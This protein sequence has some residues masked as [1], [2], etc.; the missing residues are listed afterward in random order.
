MI[1]LLLVSVIKKIQPNRY[2]F[3]FIFILSTLGIYGQESELKFP[4]ATKEK[5]DEYKRE[6]Q[7]SITSEINAYSKKKDEVVV[8]KSLE[9]MQVL[10]YLEDDGYDFLKLA[11]KDYSNKSENFYNG[12]LETA[13]ALYQTGFE[14]E[15]EKI[16]A[17]ST[18]VR[19]FTV[20]ANFLLR[21]YPEEKSTYLSTL[22]SRFKNYEKNPTLKILTKYLEIPPVEYLAKRP[23]IK[24]L[25][26]YDF[27]GNHFVLFSLQRL[28]R[29]YPGLVIIKN[30]DGKFLRRED[31]TIF[32]I[33]QLARS[34]SNLPSYLVNGN[35][36]QGI[37]SIQTIQTVKSEVIGPTPAIITALPIEVSSDK[38]FHLIKKSNSKWNLKSYLDLFPSSWKNYFPIQ[39]AYIAGEIGRSGIYAHGTTVDTEL[40][41]DYSYYPNT[42]TRGC[43]S[44]K[45]IWSKKT[46]KLMYS[47][48]L[49]LLNA[50]KMLE[51]T[52]GYMVVVEL[53]DREMPVSLDEVLMDIL[54]ME[55]GL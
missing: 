32:S 16:L 43:L 28:N 42:P 4:A 30:P 2:I 35:T 48:Q 45:E 9:Y 6:I 23:P 31:G 17:N 36:P 55:E 3:L 19:H 5:R 21:I 11:L 24:D 22:Q 50:V 26:E 14:V 37:F 39:E 46:G 7:K 10:N 27:G 53:D 25:L 54:E 38:F 51:L 40:F 44:A 12:V 15:M 49:S 52:N 47:D 34:I 1:L 8:K 33:S 29:D 13:F 18:N 41:V 20:A